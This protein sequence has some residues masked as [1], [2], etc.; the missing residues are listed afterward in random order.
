MSKK[1]KVLYPANLSSDIFCGKLLGYSYSDTC[2]F[3]IVS[4][5]EIINETNNGLKII[6]TII[7]KDEEGFYE[8]IYSF[9]NTV[10][11]QKQY[12]SK[13]KINF[14]E[15]LFIRNSDSI[16]VESFDGKVCE[17]EEY[18]IYQDIFSRNLGIIESKYLSSKCA[19]IC[20][21]GSVG[22]LVAIELAKSGVGNFL[23]IDNDILSYTNISRHQCGIKSVGCYKVK[24]VKEKILDI[25]PNSKVEVIVDIIENVPKN[26][27]DNYCNKDTIFFGCGDNRQSDRYANK[28]SKIYKSAFVSIGLWNRAF[29]GEI[30]YTLF[31][32]N[33]CYDCYQSS[34]E[35]NTNTK[36]TN[37]RFYT[38]EEDLKKLNFEPGISIDI[39]YVTLVGIKIAIDIYNIDNPNVSQKILPYIT[40]LTWVC[41]NTDTKLGG[42]LA[43]LFT[44]PLQVCRSIEVE[45]NDK[46]CQRY[47]CCKYYK[48]R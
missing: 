23:L 46:D 36:Q 15:I 40:N 33:I 42:D 6:G 37:N 34:I 4:T 22:S 21:C 41:N 12:I 14:D 20:G 48:N 26:I 13:P 18:S 11:S 43:E 8:N 17:I 5:N 29:A 1:I 7:N 30:F 44:F 10:P 38:T 19:V 32:Q 9:D 24:A 35:F 3:N 27:F 28:L 2:V 25:N 31:N 39:N 45:F 47:N 16:V